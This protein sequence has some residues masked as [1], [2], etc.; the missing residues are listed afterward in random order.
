MELT[1][2]DLASTVAHVQ[3][4][5]SAADESHLVDAITGLDYALVCAL[6][7]AG[8][9]PGQQSFGALV[10]AYRSYTA[11]QSQPRREVLR[12]LLHAGDVDPCRI[13]DGKPLLHH[14]CAG[15]APAQDIQ[16]LLETGAWQAIN[17]RDDNGD[18]PLLHYC[19]R[20]MEAPRTMAG[21]SLLLD[22][23]AEPNASNRGQTS[24]K[25]LQQGGQQER[26]K[27]LIERLLEYGAVH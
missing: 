27:R 22:A 16:V 26:N 15:A 7:K 3:A 19:R 8:V 18:T 23:G 1:T 2:E 9:T 10:A 20:G 11:S 4:C 25:L 21:L 12:V 24:Y 5:L 14:L 6:L 13:I 17:D